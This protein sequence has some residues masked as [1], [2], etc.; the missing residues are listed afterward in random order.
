MWDAGVTVEHS[1]GRCA[2]TI[3]SAPS[4]ASRGCARSRGLGGRPTCGLCCQYEA[5]EGLRTS[6]WPTCGLCCS[7]AVLR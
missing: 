2:A 3:W 5:C 7:A 1:A 6:S 4:T